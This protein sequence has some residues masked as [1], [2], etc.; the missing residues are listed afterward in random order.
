MRR[1]SCAMQHH[2]Q[3]VRRRRSSVI[4][5][6]VVSGKETVDFSQALSGEGRL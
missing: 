6:S 1:A 3:K 2:L 4:G 5:V